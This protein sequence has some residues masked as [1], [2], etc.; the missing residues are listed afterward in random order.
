[1]SLETSTLKAHYTEGLK[2][3]SWSR[4]LIE[5]DKNDK[6]ATFNIHGALEALPKSELYA[7]RAIAAKFKNYLTYNPET[8]QWYFWDGK[9]HRPCVGDGIVKKI[10]KIYFDV[11]MQGLDTIDTY[12]KKAIDDAADPVKEK[13]AWD[14]RLKDYKDF[15]DF[16]SKAAGH[17]AIVSILKTEVDVASDHF[18]NDRRW[19]V[20]ENGVYDMDDVRKTGVFTR[21]EHDPARPVY[22]MWNLTEEVGASH[23]ALDKFTS[24][25]IE[26]ASQAAFFQKIVGT[27]CMGI[28][29]DTRSVVSLQGAPNSGKSMFIRV[30]TAFGKDF[31]AAPQRGAITRGGKNP[32][33]SRN[34]MKGARFI[35][36]TEITDR[37]DREFF[38]KFS[39]GDEIT[40]EEKYVNNT[41]WFPEGVMFLF[42]NKGMN[43]DKSDKAT[44][45]RIKP[46]HFP[47]TFMK[48]SI[49]GH[50]L[51]TEL[52]SKIIAQ[53]S[54]FLEWLK[55]G[56]LAGL[57]EGFDC[58][59]SMDALKRGERDDDDDVALFLQSRIGEGKEFIEDKTAHIKNCLSVQDLYFSYKQWVGSYSGE[60]PMMRKD[61]TERVALHYPKQK[62][63]SFHF[64]GLVNNPNYYPVNAL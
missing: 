55:A 37:L 43:I 47:Y 20:I 16:L 17:N 12:I 25:S 30:M 50:E 9:I 32:E 49:D 44:F 22:R 14:Y 42:S 58:S 19:F 2:L 39:G 26:D 35:S 33:H 15:R 56:Y 53:G 10:A 28:T 6:G 60:K 34:P 59:D 1:M 21:L 24:E 11:T 38:L 7:G 64:T 4:D 46:I 61:F 40:S 41:G 3:Y 29:T 8:S 48:G 63:T 52:E 45:D 54:G 5:H 27:A 62:Y 51:D 57:A 31:K 13:A 36:F 23:D 18:S